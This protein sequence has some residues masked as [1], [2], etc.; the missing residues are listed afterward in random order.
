MRLNQE[1][2]DVLM[3]VITKTMRGEPVTAKDRIAI[4][5]ARGMILRESLSARDEAL[6]QDGLVE[7]LSCYPKKAIEALEKGSVTKR[8]C[9]AVVAYNRE[10]QERTTRAEMEAASERIRR[11][12]MEA[13][14]ALRQPSAEL[15]VRCDHCDDGTEPHTDNDVTGPQACSKCIGNQF[16]PYLSHLGAADKEGGKG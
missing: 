3:S 10:L 16:I 6:Q 13:A 12:K 15:F 2:A 14:L 5:T 7:R 9:A 11:E 8:Q 4:G 1:I